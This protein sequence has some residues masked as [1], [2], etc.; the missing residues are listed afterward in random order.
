M[1]T[2]VVTERSVMGSHVEGAPKRPENPVV[3][4]GVFTGDWKDTELL[5]TF[6]S[7]RGRIRAARMPR[8]TLRAQA[9]GGDCDPQ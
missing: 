4:K 9:P 2:S 6:L 5:R 3:P 7:H 8:L 1:K